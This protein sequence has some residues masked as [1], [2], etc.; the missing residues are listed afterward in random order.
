MSAE[1]S[2][3]VTMITI[4]IDRIAAMW[5][6]GMPK[7]SGVGSATSGPSGTLEKSAMPQNTATT[8]PITI[9][10]RID[11]REMLALPSLLSSS[12][13]ARVKAARPTLAMLPNSGD[14]LLPPI[15]QRAA[16]GIRV[17]PMVVM[18]MP[19]TS[20]GKNLVIREN[21][22]VIN[23]PISEAAI[24][25]PST[26]GMPPAPSL[27]MIAIMVATPAKDTPCTSGN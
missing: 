25:A 5:N 22:G 27:P 8:V 4:S 6:S 16:T 10:R 24:T 7:C 11:R 13:V 12:T 23:R 18:T 19:V 1:V 15:A 9:A 21:T 2:T 14:W 26:T 17:R 20:G 3:R